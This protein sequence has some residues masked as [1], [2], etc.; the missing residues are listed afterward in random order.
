MCAAAYSSSSSRSGTISIEIL[1]VTANNQ[2]HIVFLNGINQYLAQIAAAAQ[3]FSDWIA[4]T[5]GEFAQ[6]VVSLFGDAFLHIPQVNV[7]KTGVQV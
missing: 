3:G 5:R 1:V 4:G 2:V 7:D 6:R